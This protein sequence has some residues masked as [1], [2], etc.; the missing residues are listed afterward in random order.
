MESTVVDSPMRTTNLTALTL[1]VTMVLSVVAPGAVV[2]Q[3]A[4][5]G[6][7]SL[8]V[9]T[10]AP[11]NV[12]A[13]SATLNGNLTALS[14]VDNATVWFEYW[15][16]GDTANTT[17]TSES[18]LDAPG[19]FEASIGDLDNDTTYV[20]Q[21]HARAN[22]TTVTGETVAFTTDADAA[23]DA[24]KNFGLRVSDFI[25]GLLDGGIDDDETF[26]RL[27]AQF[28]VANNPGSDN[29][30]DH[31]GPPW[32]DDDDGDDD[33]N[34]TD[35]DADD[36]R[37]PP[38]HAGPPDHAG[39]KD[40]GEEDESDGDDDAETDDEAEQDED[41]GEEEDETDEGESEGHEADE[42]DDDDSDDN[43]PPEHAGPPD[44]DDDEDA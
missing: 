7:T 35:D 2:A 31:A 44:D 21:A 18:T 9:S 11:T 41:E 8:S 25:H 17:N 42:D 28:V 24:P 39:P 16:E 3:A 4:A 15:I 30:P 43:G 10:D 33:G 19:E 1:V 38:E 32:L 12:T 37:G 5:A 6:N 36:N 23:E 27:V 20:Y 26:G 13:T 14:G 40:E 34:E 22:G 29:R